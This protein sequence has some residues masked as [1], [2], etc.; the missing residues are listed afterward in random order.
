MQATKMRTPFAIQ[1]I[2]GLGV[3]SAAAAA[4]ANYQQAQ[5]LSQQQQQQQQ[6]QHSQ[7]QQQPLQLQQQQSPTSQTQQPQ[8]Q[9]RHSS[10]TTNCTPPPPA[11]TPTATECN[12]APLS[13]ASSHGRPTRDSRSISPDV[14]RLSAAA[15]AAA[16]TA[17]CQLPIFN[18]ANFYAAA[19]YADHAGQLNAAHHH[20]MTTLAA[21]AYLRGFLPPGFST[22]HEFRGHFQQHFGSQFA[23]EC[24]FSVC[25]L[26]IIFSRKNF[27]SRKVSLAT[28]KVFR[29]VY[30]LKEN[31][32]LNEFC[33][34]FIIF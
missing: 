28:F 8:Q 9:Q 4:A 7:Q 10:T 32:F 23:G 21:A 2:L 18:P 1:E 29:T 27:F 26:D 14:T 24:E 12:N 31:L 16:A 20:H 25:Y 13:P 11:A 17:H 19:G 15:A 5:Q 6:L 30:E 34:I 3:G 22:P 33:R